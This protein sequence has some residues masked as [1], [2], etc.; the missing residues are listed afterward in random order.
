MSGT[1]ARTVESA[2]M[3][4]WAG[5]SPDDAPLLNPYKNERANHKNA[6]TLAAVWED[7]FT[8]EYKRAEAERQHE[9]EQSE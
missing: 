3:A 9:Q 1:L 6:D 7:A 4:V 2:H 5:V 8:T